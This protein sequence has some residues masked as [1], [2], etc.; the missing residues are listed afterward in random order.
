M[1]PKTTPLDTTPSPAN[2]KT[3]ARPACSILQKSSAPRCKMPDPSPRL[4]GNPH[5]SQRTGQSQHIPYKTSQDI[6]Y[7]LGSSFANQSGAVVDLA[8]AL[9]AH[10][11]HPFPSQSQA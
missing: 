3:W 7:S 1:T 6:P 8:S 11:F 9:Q 4:M 2:T 5:S 10:H